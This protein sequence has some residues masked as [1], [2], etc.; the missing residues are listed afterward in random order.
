MRAHMNGMSIH[1]YVFALFMQF[2]EASFDHQDLLLRRAVET[3]TIYY[4]E[5][6]G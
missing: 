2:I 1:M 5:P 6:L 3:G 4:K